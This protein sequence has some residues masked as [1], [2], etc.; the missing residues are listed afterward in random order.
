MSPRDLKLALARAP[1]AVGVD[2]GAERLLAAGFPPDAVTGDFDSISPASLAAIP[3]ER[4]YPTPDQ[5]HT[6]F[7]KAL[8]VIS[9]P[10]ILAVGFTGAR[11]DHGLAVMNALIRHP[12][13]RCIVIGPKDIVFIAPPRM[14]LQMHPDDPLS[15]FPM[16]PVSGRS[17]G[18]HWPIQGLDFAPWGMIGTS[19]RVSTR[20]V[21]LAFD[22]PGML[23]I[24]PRRR[25]DVAITALLAAPCWV[26]DGQSARG[27]S[28]R[29]LTPR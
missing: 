19:N 23:A 18:L 13:R 17:N 10:L 27:E 5:A 28:C 15:L 12:H 14:T 2:S 11:V 29:D 22:G 9:S 3:A 26:A 25:L 24:L 1:F 20:K 21:D 7:D 6:D 8:Q 16:A 4:L